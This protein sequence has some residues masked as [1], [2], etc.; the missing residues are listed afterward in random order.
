MSDVRGHLRPCQWYG[1]YIDILPWKAQVMRAERT[2]TQYCVHLNDLD[3]AKVLESDDSDN[4][5]WDDIDKN[6]PALNVE[7][8][9]FFG[10]YIWYE[11]NIEDDKTESHKSVFDII[12]KFTGEF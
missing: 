7:Y 9:G 1:G 11:F 5:C 4:P 8:D 12:R 10:P 6:T 3:M 2:R